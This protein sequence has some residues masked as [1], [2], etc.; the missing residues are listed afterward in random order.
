MN[1]QPALPDQLKRYL[2]RVGAEW[3]A[4]LV[5][6]APLSSDNLLRWTLAFDDW[7]RTILKRQEGQRAYNKVLVAGWRK[8]INPLPTALHHD[9]L[10][11]HVS[12][13][14]V[15]GQSGER[16]WRG[17]LL[18]IYEYRTNVLFHHVTDLKLSEKP[19]PAL[20]WFAIGKACD[21]IVRSEACPNLTAQKKIYLPTEGEVAGA[22]VAQ[23][24]YAGAVDQLRDAQANPLG[25]LWLK[26]RGRNI[27]VAA[28]EW[29]LCR[30][31][32]P[33]ASPQRVRA[34]SSN[35]FRRQ[36]TSLA[37]QLTKRLDKQSTTPERITPCWIP[38]NAARTKLPAGKPDTV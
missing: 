20:L 34:T 25:T 29:S 15:R 27:K 32:K 17:L 6:L 9:G 26:W 3:F 23:R 31:R 16:K 22:A 8:V 13:V 14:E 24:L 36:L 21:M 10:E 4:L 38:L 12:H 11:F 7:R 28:N 5:N 35:E 18:L 37:T 30:L 2:G 33:L 1:D 19:N